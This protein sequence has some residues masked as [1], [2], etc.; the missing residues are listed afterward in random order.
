MTSVEIA[1]FLFLNRRRILYG[2]DSMLGPLA[3]MLFSDFPVFGSLH[4][5]LVTI[6]NG[7][8]CEISFTTSLNLNLQDLS[9]QVGVKREGLVQTRID[10]LVRL[11]GGSK[12]TG[13]V[14]GEGKRKLPTDADSPGAKTRRLVADRPV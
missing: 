14:R 10:N 3:V 12:I 8:D 4:E 11:G 9:N 1:Y 6:L 2:S 13:L 5:V 7:V